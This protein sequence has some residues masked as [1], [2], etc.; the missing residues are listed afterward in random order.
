[1]PSVR[2]PPGI[3][4]V[5]LGEGQ[6]DF[7]LVLARFSGR[8]GKTKPEINTVAN[9][10]IAMVRWCDGALSSWMLFLSCPGWHRAM[11]VATPSA[12]TALQ[13]RWPR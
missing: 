4:G 5:P 13:L 6:F 7:V 2:A 11:L 3:D 12:P 8:A 1:M 9:A 10:A